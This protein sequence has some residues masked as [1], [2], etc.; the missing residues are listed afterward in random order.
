[1]KMNR[2]Y[3]L[4]LILSA[5]LCIAGCKDPFKD[6]LFRAYDEVPVAT[7]LSSSPD[8][9]VWVSML[10]RADVLNALNLGSAE[11]TC[12]AVKN[13]AAEEYLRDKGWG[14]VEEIPQDEL[15]Y[16]MRYHIISGKKYNYSDLLLKLGNPT[17]SGDYLTA[18]LDVDTEAR[19]IDNGESA[20]KSYV[21]EK[22]I[23]ASNGIIQCLDYPLQPITESV[24]DMISRSED[25]TIFAA[26]LEATGLSEWLSETYEELNGSSVRANKTVFVVSDEVFSASGIADFDVLKEYFSSPDPS[27]KDSKLYQFMLY[28]LFDRLVGYADLTTFPDGYKSM[29]YYCCSE[30]KGLSIIDQDGKITFNPDESGKSF[31]IVDSMRDIPAKNGYIHEIDNLGE[32]PVTMSHYIVVF[33]PTDYFEYNGIPIYRSGA[34]GSD[35][36]TYYLTDCEM[37]FPGIRWESIPESKASVWYDVE[38]LDRYLNKD[39]IYWNLGNIGWIEFDIPVLPLGKY[40]IDCEKYNVSS[41]GGKC[42][43]TFDNAT[44]NSTGSINF[45]TGVNHAAW[46]EFKIS[47][48]E[49]HVIRFTVSEQSGICGVDRFIFVPI[50]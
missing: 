38:N 45:A 39:A 43:G 42:S 8:Y 10:K 9:S 35:V 2:I 17:V 21:I 50:D 48:E 11:Y 31:H 49:P 3:R 46:N 30:K 7:T 19:Y 40:R 26:A 16:L 6:T 12:F 20:R 22:D 18:G 23:A 4:I 5:A 28:H 37:T 29:I 36:K 33:E 41:K 14:S 44:I 27:D 13:E 47:T 15:D 24:W 25:Y 34:T 32:L 1:M